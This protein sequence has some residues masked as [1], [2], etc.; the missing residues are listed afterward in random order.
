M[1]V[2]SAMEG[3]CVPIAVSELHGGICGSLCAGGGAAVPAWVEEC[4]GDGGPMEGALEAARHQL[5]ELELYS[6]RSL[7]ASGLE[8]YPLLPDD[9]VTLIERVGALALWCNGFLLGLGLAGFS[10]DEGQTGATT[11][12]L[13]EI[14][15]DFSEI[16]RAAVDEDE[17]DNQ[18]EADFALAKLIEH[19]RVSVQIVF[20]ELEPKRATGPGA[21]TVH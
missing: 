8:F 13:E 4:L 19:V 11:T 6:W 15:S 5:R 20:E 16:S 21:V 3:A 14:L 10:L 7:S 2:H 17:F 9:D 1:T 12:E 18:D